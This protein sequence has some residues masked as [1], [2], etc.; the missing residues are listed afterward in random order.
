MDTPEESPK[1]QRGAPPLANIGE[2][3]SKVKRGIGQWRGAR[4]IERVGTFGTLVILFGGL[5][6]LKL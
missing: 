3:F 5:C 1:V 2:H 4:P 6:W